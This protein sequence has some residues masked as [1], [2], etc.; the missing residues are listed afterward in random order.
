MYE[1]LHG[2]INSIL[3]GSVVIDV[4]GVGYLVVVPM[5]LTDGLKCGDSTRLLIH[6]DF[7][8]NKGENRLYGFGDDF[9]R[10]VFRALLTVKGVGAKGAMKMLVA[11]PASRLARMIKDGDVA[12]LSRV[13]GLGGKSA[14]RVVVEL[15]SGIDDF[16]PS[17]PTAA[18]GSENIDAAVSAL[19]HLG[20][21]RGEARKRVEKA[22]KSAPEGEVQDLVKAALM[23]G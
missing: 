12:G 10:G 5:T 4:G 2:E 23:T 15:Q 19:E 6:H 11:M 14:Q 3:P 20:V 22:L 1:H 21:K 13:R 7:D 18:H 9:E 17:A 16:L 8:V